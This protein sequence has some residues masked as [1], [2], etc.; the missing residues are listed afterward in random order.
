[1]KRII[2]ILFS[3]LICTFIT[4]Q[5]GNVGVGTTSPQAK[6]HV[7]GDLR[8]DDNL[9]VRDS[10][11]EPIIIL[12]P[13]TKQFE[14]LDENGDV[15]YRVS[16]ENDT[17]SAAKINNNSRSNASG[18]PTVTITRTANGETQTTTRRPDGTIQ[19]EKFV[20]DFGNF[21][22]KFYP[23]GVTPRQVISEGFLV[24][25]D[26]I[27]DFNQDGV[28]TKQKIEGWDG[29][30]SE[31]LFH[32][33]GETPK[34][35]V[36]IFPSPSNEIISE[37]YDENGELIEKK[38]FKSGLTKLFDKDDNEIAEME[39]QNGYMQTINDPSS[40]YSNMTCAFG[41]IIQD[42][43]SGDNTTVNAGNIN[44]QKDGKSLN[45]KN[46]GIDVTD[47]N[48]NLQ[49]FI[50]VFGVSKFENGSF[51]GLD[52]NTAG[53]V[54]DVFGDLDVGGMISKGGG[55]FKIDHPLDP[56]NKFLY[57]S[58][59]ESPD[60]MNVYNGNIITDASGESIVKLPDY[61]EALN[62]DFRYQLTVVGSFAQAVVWKKVENNQFMIKTDKPNIE[63]S[64][65]VTGIRNDEFA[66]ANRVQVEVEKEGYDK[67]KLIFD[68]Q[69]D[70]PYAQNMKTHWD[71]YQRSMEAKRK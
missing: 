14:I 39:L 16:V 30:F 51:V 49:F 56:T 42:S 2:I 22:T 34:S 62:I 59:V 3:F 20:G 50:D 8:V 31:T 60:M 17:T 43:D 36:I 65:Q 61:F 57:H 47:P 28:K 25:A 41:N 55:T 13:N 63:V 23:D 33:D 15:F 58:F 12:N 66:K 6:L 32:E 35:T 44:I 19:S 11:N 26:I 21:E 4:A 40:G 64:W 5:D 54:V 46:E 48:A 53:G 37:K 45:L 1:M 24:S 69:R 68:P 52:F 27:T 9:E 18:E 70:E 29:S 67:G 38:S 10:T 71:K 7:K